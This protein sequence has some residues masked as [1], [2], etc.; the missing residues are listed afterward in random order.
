MEV[1]N[2]LIKFKL[3]LDNVFEG[4]LVLNERNTEQLLHWLEHPSE[5]S[6]FIVIGM[7]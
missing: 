2:H 3:L 5:N 1:E 4:K 6:K 7:K